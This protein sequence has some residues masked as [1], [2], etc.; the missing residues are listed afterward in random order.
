MKPA[1]L[2]SSRGNI[3]RSEGAPKKSQY[4]PLALKELE[5]ETEKRLEHLRANTDLSFD[6]WLRTEKNLPEQP[7][8]IL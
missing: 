6:E 8:R 4:D 5:I 3:K 1:F 2:V 7:K